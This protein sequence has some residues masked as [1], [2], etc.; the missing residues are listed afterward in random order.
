M[1][2]RPQ[3]DTE[4]CLLLHTQLFLIDMRDHSLVRLSEL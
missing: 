1:P 2:L 3:A 4:G